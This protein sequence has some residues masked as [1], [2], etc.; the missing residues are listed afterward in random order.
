MD[1]TEA[2]IEHIEAVM[3]APKVRITVEGNL[4]IVRFEMV[5]IP[6]SPLGKR[7]T[8]LATR[9][10]GEFGWRRG[11]TVKRVGILDSIQF[12]RS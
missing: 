3:S 1:L 12:D 6:S 8:G 10:R 9:Y 11:R 5:K 7:L 2:P 4:L